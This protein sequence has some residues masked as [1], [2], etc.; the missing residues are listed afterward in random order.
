[1]GELACLPASLLGVATY[2]LIG[3]QLAAFIGGNV[4]LVVLLI[5]SQLRGEWHEWV[6]RR[7]RGGSYATRISTIATEGPYPRT[8]THE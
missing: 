8:G 3:T 7:R 4:S 6:A 2:H 5:G 1:M